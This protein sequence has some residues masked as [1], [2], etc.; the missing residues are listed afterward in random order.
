[1]S[2]QSL[3]LVLGNA[4]IQPICSDLRAHRFQA[5]LNEFGIDPGSC[6]GFH[7][8]LNVAGEVV[9]KNDL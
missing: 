8:F 6:P 9:P 1:M 4:L 7:H 3:I 2:T 5:W